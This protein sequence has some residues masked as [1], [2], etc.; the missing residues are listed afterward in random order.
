MQTGAFDTTAL[1]SKDLLAEAN[2]RV[3][4]SLA[5]L[6]GMVRMQARALGKG[7]AAPSTAELKLMFDGMAARISTIGQLHRMLAHMPVDA[8]IPLD[9]HLRDITAMLVSAFSSEHQPVHVEHTGGAC[10]VLTRHVQPLTLVVCEIITNALK[11]AHPAGG[12]PVLLSVDCQSHANG[13]LE[14]CVSDDGVGLPEGFD[15]QHG[16]GIGFQL[17]RALTSEMGGTLEINSD[18]LGTAFRIKVP[19]ALVANARSA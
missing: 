6:S 7:P 13:L 9:T 11:Y 10:L 4:N 5:L 17:M 18:T 15:S 19:Q 8:A 16:G 12:V 1:S 14:V 3:A 2:H